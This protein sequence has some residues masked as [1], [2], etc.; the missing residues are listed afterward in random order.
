MPSPEYQG[1]E[2]NDKYK[3]LQEQRRRHVAA[4]NLMLSVADD[5]DDNVA[6]F[7]LGARIRGLEV[8][9]MLVTFNE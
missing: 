6:L 9:Q 2:P 3:D 7:E 8:R 5:P 4:Y 1:V